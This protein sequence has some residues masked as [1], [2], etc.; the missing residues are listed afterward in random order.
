MLGITK[1]DDP[2]S[3]TTFDKT[4]SVV[5]AVL[6]KSYSVE[7]KVNFRDKSKSNPDTEAYCVSRVII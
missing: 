2:T 5:V 3:V 6:L 1:L 4:P 7:S